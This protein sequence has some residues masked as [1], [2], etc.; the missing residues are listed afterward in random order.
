MLF[1]HDPSA[2]VAERGGKQLS[3][4]VNKAVTNLHSAPALLR[5]DLQKRSDIGVAM[6]NSAVRPWERSI[7]WCIVDE[8]LPHWQGTWDAR[9][10]ETLAKWQDLKGRIEQ[11]GLPKDHDLPPLLDVSR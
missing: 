10:D 9:A 6:Q 2:L 4:E 1:R 7:V 11:L 8:I 5:T 3:N